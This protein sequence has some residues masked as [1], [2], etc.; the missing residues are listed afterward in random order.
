MRR[1]LPI[2]IAGVLLA[3]LAAYGLYVFGVHRGIAS[4]S[5][6]A[7]ASDPA[8][9]SVGPNGA[10]QK[11]SDP[12]GKILYWHDPMVP[13]PRFDRPGKSPFMDMQLVPVY[14]REGEDADTVR[15]DP[16]IQQ[17]L[18]VRTA[19]VE[20]GSVALSA[21]VPGNVTYDERDLV[22]VEARASGFVERLRVRAPFDR[23]KKGQ[24]LAEIYVP[25]WTAVEEDYLAAARMSGS[26]RDEIV[27]ASLERMRQSGMTSEQIHDFLQNGS[28]QH[29][30]ELLAPTSGVVTDLAL[31]EGMTFAPGAPLFRINGLARVWLDASV[32][33]S[34]APSARPGTA[35]QVTVPA[36]PGVTFKATVTALLPEVD[37]VTRTMRARIELANS[38][39]RLVPGMFATIRLD[40]PVAATAL[41]VP[42]EAVIRTGRRCVVVVVTTN[43]RFSPTEVEV[44]TE[45][46]GQTEIRKGLSRGQRVVTSGQFLIDSEASLTS[47]DARMAPPTP[48]QLPQDNR[49]N[50][51]PAKP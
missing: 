15:I 47:S 45:R 11:P 19:L 22:V 13:G 32:P 25:D 24:V 27:Q 4:V 7:R 37:A 48:D 31:R 36:I 33:Q 23:V 44:G 29:R 43:G 40:P 38:D 26:S 1:A 49:A 12:G 8:L 14:A 28:V 20:E 50:G 2:G 30:V 9:G 17:N 42:S 35:V 39:G 10:L 18:G 41:L 34:M 51:K 21:S 16:R 46:E 5:M 3:T 6:S